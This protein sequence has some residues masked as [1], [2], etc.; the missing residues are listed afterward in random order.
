VRPARFAAALLGAGALCCAPA[1]VRPTEAD[2]LRAAAR[3]QGSG[4]VDLEKGRAVYVARCG[5]CHELILPEE[6]KAEEWPRLVGRMSE[7]AKLAA[8]ERQLVERF[9]VTLAERS[10]AGK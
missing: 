3:W 1:L 9:L 6:Q 8:E 2:G 5:K 7:K 4:L 10:P